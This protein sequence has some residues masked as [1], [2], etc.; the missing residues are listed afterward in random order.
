MILEKI[1]KI[2]TYCLFT[3]ALV[4]TAPSLADSSA[5]VEFIRY[6][7][8]RVDNTIYLSGQ[9]GTKP[10]TIELVEGG[11]KEETRQALSNI[12]AVLESID[13]SM[14]NIVKC[15]AILVDIGEWSEFNEVY[16]TFF[17]GKRPARTTFGAGGLALGGR[18]EIECL[19]VDF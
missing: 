17:T 9:M 11:I 13:L 10:G 16:K 5:S 14:G 15:T 19:A 4:I 12:K 1:I 8:V 2:K 7:L 3:L 6:G 18:V